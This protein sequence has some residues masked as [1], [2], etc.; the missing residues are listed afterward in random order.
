MIAPATATQPHKSR[1]PPPLL[2]PSAP[3]ASIGAMVARSAM[4]EESL[5]QV[6]RTP[7]EAY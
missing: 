4:S 1:A 2:P 3:S 6:V 7:A 5:K